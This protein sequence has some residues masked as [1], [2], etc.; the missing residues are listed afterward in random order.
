M[1]KT[2]VRYDVPLALLVALTTAL[3]PTVAISATYYVGPDGNDT[4]G[5][6]SQSN[7]WRSIGHAVTKASTSA[8]IKVMDDDNGATD[9]YVESITVNKSL[10]I[11]RY[12]S[13]GPNPQ[14]AASSVNSSVFSIT[15]DNVTIRGLDI[16]G[17]GQPGTAGIDL[18]NVKNCTIQNNRCGWDSSHENYCGIHLNSSSNNT[19]EGNTCN[20]NSEFGG[21]TPPMGMGYAIYLNSSS[22]NTLTG[23]TCS[24]NGGGLSH[25]GYGIYLNSSNNNKIIL[26]NKCESNG[27]AGIHLKS[28]SGNTLSGN[29]CTSNGDGL[30]FAGDGISL[31]SCSNNTI[32]GN[33][34]DDNEVAGISLDSS[35][36]NKIISSNSCCSNGGLVLGYGVSLSASSNN[37]ISG[38]TCKSNQAA[39]ISD[40]DSYR[41]TTNGITGSV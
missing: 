21:I 40:N 9:D 22:N 19:L 41:S 31:S 18:A 11:E 20:D 36:N 16:Y 24:E 34:C 4:T 6:G 28:S 13:T 39:M 29:T 7:P 10:T 2:K 14:V 38:N 5:N 35:N 3:M 25:D 1:V 17:A 26:G 37:T 23:N 8:V 12:N 15:A 33:K 30:G 32:S 27:R